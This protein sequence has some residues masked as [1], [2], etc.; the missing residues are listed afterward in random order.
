MVC[1]VEEMT[2]F[3]CSKFEIFVQ[4]T[5]FPAWAPNSDTQTKE[6]YSTDMEDDLLVTSNRFGLQ[7]GR[8]H[9]SKRIEGNDGES[10]S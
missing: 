3:P 9:K 5:I 2:G 1:T 8:E 6:V 10:S 7:K 4:V